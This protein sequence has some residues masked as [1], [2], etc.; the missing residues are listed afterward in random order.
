MLIFRSRERRMCKMKLQAKAVLVFPVLAVLVSAQPPGPNRNDSQETR[1]RGYWIDPPTG[2]MWAGKDNGKDVSWKGAV[3]YCRDLRLA[4][5]SNWRLATVAELRAIYNP[6]ANA[7][8]SA[9][10][11]KD[12]LFTY[13]VKGNLFLTGDEWSSE[14]RYDNRGRPDGYAWYFDFNEGRAD[15][16]PSG[17]PYPHSLMRALC[18]CGSGK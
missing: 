4:G 13:H 17:F 5:Y 15:N 3:K 11:G 6:N 12:N 2:L 9:G 16:D 18:V 7:L 8:G 1:V 14:R 10:S